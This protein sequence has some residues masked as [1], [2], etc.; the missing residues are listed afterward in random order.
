MLE[1]G[2]RNAWNGLNDLCT[3]VLVH[4]NMLVIC[5]CRVVQNNNTEALLAMNI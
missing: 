2:T 3:A 5:G 1:Q 4:I